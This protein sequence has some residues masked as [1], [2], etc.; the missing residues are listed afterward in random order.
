MHWNPV[1][2]ELGIH[3]YVGSEIWPTSDDEIIGV[4]DE[5]GGC[6]ERKSGTCAEVEVE[7]LSAGGQRQEE[8]RQR[9]PVIVGQGKCSSVSFLNAEPF[10]SFDRSGWHV[11]HG[12]CKTHKQKLSN[13]PVV[14]V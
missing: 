11:Q 9:R 5:V 4:V 3:F 13:L 10:R 1:K 7:T 8:Q 2:H 6:T 14:R 12:T